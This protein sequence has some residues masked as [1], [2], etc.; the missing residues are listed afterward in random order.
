MLQNLYLLGDINFRGVSDPRGLF[1]HVSAPLKQA[2]MVFANLECCLYDPPADATE[3]RGFYVPPAVGAALVQAGVQV[4]GSANNV[5][6]GGEAVAG[7]L[8]ELDRLGIGH[9]GAGLDAESARAG[10]VLE[11]NGVRYGFM[12]R[13]AVYWPENHEA[14]AGQPGVA[15]IKGHTAYQPAMDQ[16]AARTRPGVPPRV[17]TWADPDSLARYRE[18]VAELRKRAD[19]VVT[20]LHWGFRREVLHYQREFAHASVDAGADIVF[21]HGPHMILPI[22]TYRGKPIFYGGGNFS[23]QMAHQNDPHTDW[24]GMMI[25][26]AVKNGRIEEIELAFTQRNA[27]NQTLV[28]PVESFEHECELL[29][30]TSFELGATLQVRDDKLMWRPEAA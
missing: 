30:K 10:L 8:A 6:I 5:N 7:S 4:V 3:K 2:D 12:Q 18:D 20:S 9:V 24:V 11:R 13:T 28:R 15:I 27:A 25:R 22:E 1:D 26:A 29:L 23:F 21:G 19:V 17:I 14:Q 16:Q